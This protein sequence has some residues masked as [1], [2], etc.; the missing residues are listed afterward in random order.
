MRKDSE[1]GVIHL[2]QQETRET[3]AALRPQHTRPGCGLD[4]CEIVVTAIRIE[5][6][7]IQLTPAIVATECDCMPAFTPRQCV[8]YIRQVADRVIGPL[9]ANAGESIADVELR[10]GWSAD[11]REPQLGGPVRAA[12]RAHREVVTVPTIKPKVQMI[13]Q[14]GTEG[15]IPTEPAVVGNKVLVPA[16][17]IDGRGQS[18]GAARQQRVLPGVVGGEDLVRIADVLIDAN[19]VGGVVGGKA[20]AEIKVVLQAGQVRWGHVAEGF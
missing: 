4:I 11:I 13:Q 17:W 18:W 15:V 3:I 9:L 14:A 6:K 2:A 19:G 8:A 1:A 5:R 16:I 7:V 12:G 10:K 20:A